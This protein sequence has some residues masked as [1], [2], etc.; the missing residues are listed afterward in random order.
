MKTHCRPAF[1]MSGAALLLLAAATPAVAGHSTRA[2]RAE[3]EATRQLNLQAAQ[4]G[5]QQAQAPQPAKVAVTDAAANVPDNTPPAAA[6]TAPIQAMQMAAAEPAATALPLSSIT[7]PPSKIATA[8]VLDSSGQ[9]VGAVQKI[10]V[11]PSGAP[12]KVVVALAGTQEKI[13]V[14]DAN[15]VSYDPA[16]NEITAKASGA[17]IKALSSG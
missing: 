15:A 8:N 10:E 2:S 6:P 12:T 13:V 9:P 14:L 16:V 4:Q 3:I 1:Q 11:S 5:Q 17:Q 7:N